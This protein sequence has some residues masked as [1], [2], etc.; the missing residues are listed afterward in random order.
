MRA[1]TS[2]VLAICGTHLGDTKLPASTAEW[3]AEDSASISAT[4]AS[5]GTGLA[6]FC[7]PSRGPTST[8]RTFFGWFMFPPLRQRRP[9]LAGAAEDDRNRRQRQDRKADQQGC[10]GGDGRIDLEN[11]LVEHLLRHGLVAA[12]DERRHDH[13][14]ETADEGE[15]P[16]RKDAGC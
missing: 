4:L 16:G 10:N 2:S 12:G 15:D 3:P 9:K 13:L 5:T 14:V 7:R 1:I 8:S 11:Q 6:S